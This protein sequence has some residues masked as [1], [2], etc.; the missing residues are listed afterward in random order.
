MSAVDLAARRRGPP[1]G[2]GQLHLVAPPIP[3][4]G[5]AECRSKL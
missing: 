1:P 3:E 2:S 5:Y 4:G